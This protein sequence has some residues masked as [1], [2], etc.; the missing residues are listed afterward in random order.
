MQSCVMEGKKRSGEEK[1]KKIL[2][3]NGKTERTGKGERIEG[4]RNV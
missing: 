3:K 4:G 1:G 2:K